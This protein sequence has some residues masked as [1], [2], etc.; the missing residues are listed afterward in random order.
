M[1]HIKL[2]SIPIIFLLYTTGMVM[3]GCN[4]HPVI[5]KRNNGLSK[6][7]FATG[8]CYGNCPL[9][10][11]EIDSSLNYKFY[12]GFLSDSSGY[13]TG[14]VSQ[15]FWDTLNTKMEGIHY[16]ALDTLYSG[17]EDDL[18]IEAIL[19]FG[20]NRKRIS[21]REWSLPENVERVFMWIINSY[22]TI[23]LK[24]AP[25]QIPFET[26]IQYL[27]PLPTPQMPNMKVIRPDDD[28]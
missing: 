23:T 15:G 11:I 5:Q 24:R 12:G 14:K 22:K 10:A 19:Y 1:S 16:Y 6:V 18:N 20:D 17:S 7:C 8:G 2:P 25:Y 3:A 9:F 13:F 26:Q 28:N 21:A 27:L 4:S